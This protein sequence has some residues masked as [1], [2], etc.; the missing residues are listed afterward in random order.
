MARA[1]QSGERRCR[2]LTRGREKLGAWRDRAGVLHDGAGWAGHHHSLC[3]HPR[4]I[5]RL[6]RDPAMDGQWLQF[7]LR[8]AAADRCCA[9]RPLQP[10]GNVRC[11][12]FPV[13]PCI[14]GMRA[15]RQRGDA[16]RGAIGPGRGRRPGE[17]AG[18]G[19]SQRRVC[20]RSARAGVRH[21]QRHHRMCPHYRPRRRRLH[22]RDS[23]MAM[24]LLDQSSDRHDRHRLGAGAASREFWAAGRTGYS[25]TG[26][27]R[28]RR[29]REVAV[30]IHLSI[31]WVV[32]VNFDGLWQFSQS[33]NTP[34]PITVQA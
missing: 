24:D 9:G 13:Y 32:S 28:C 11:R 19:H 29:A 31:C 15:V 30:G 34:G 26:V 14:N 27:R 33:I 22:Y 6:D 17:P 20:Q 25:G 21:V 8:G 1:E 23:G 2:N 10:P 7:D 4:R 16:D 3:H 12:H 5:W 18:D